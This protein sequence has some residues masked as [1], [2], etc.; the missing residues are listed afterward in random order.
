MLTILLLGKNLRW[1]VGE[2]QE[3]TDV[4]HGTVL[5]EILLE[6][7]S[8]L[9]VHLQETSQALN[10]NCSTRTIDSKTRKIIK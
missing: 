5:L 6:E 1:I 9:H 2:I 10:R 8:R 3:E 4:I 7:T